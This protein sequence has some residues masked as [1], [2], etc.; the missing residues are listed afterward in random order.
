MTVNVCWDDEDKT[1]ARMD[2]IGEWTWEE[3]RQAVTQ[4]RAMMGEVTYNFNFIIDVSE[5]IG[6]PS[7][8]LSQ[9]RNVMQNSNPYMGITVLMGLNDAILIFWKIF[10]QVYGRLIRRDRYAYAKTA[11]EARTIIAAKAGLSRKAS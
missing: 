6:A 5:G 8:F 3:V 4:M 11:E 10:V 1:I 2:F 9:L 7:P